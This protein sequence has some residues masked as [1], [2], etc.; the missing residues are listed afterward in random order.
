[1]ALLA[2]TALI[3][4]VL[5]VGMPTTGVYVVVSIL[6]APALI[7][8][9]IG[10]MSA[11][12]FIFYFG[13]LS[14]LTPPVAIAS[15]AAAS[16]ANSDMWRTGLTGVQLAIVAYLLPFV[17]ALNPALLLD[18]TWIEIAVSSVT[19]LSA[20]MLLAEVLADPKA[21]GGGALRWMTGAI[22]LGLGATTAIVSP[23][24]AP[25]I[26]IAIIALPLVYGLRHFLGVRYPDSVS[27]DSR[28]TDQVEQT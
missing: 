9:G 1:M 21:F 20:G 6:L 14:M 22:A 25:A 10:D 24:S 16:I 4:I 3:A 17:F 8:A 26:A 13:L 28:T 27:N 7:R 11:H 2:V 15:Y 23:G 19:V 18:G 5:G 12:F